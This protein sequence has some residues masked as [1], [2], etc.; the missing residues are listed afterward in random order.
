MPNPY[1]VTNAAR[2]YMWPARK[3]TDIG[4]LGRHGK[5]FRQGKIIAVKGIGG[6]H[7]CC[8]GTNESAVSRLRRLKPRPV[9]PFAVMAADLET[10]KRECVVTRAA[11]ELLT[12]YERP[13]VL[14]NGGLVVRLLHLWHRIIRI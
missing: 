11:E 14:R 5:Q 1:V 7:L 8:D 6:F 2:K 9:K 13:I 4:R 12:G 3:F 10:A